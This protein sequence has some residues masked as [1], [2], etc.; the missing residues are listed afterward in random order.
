MDQFIQILT[1]PDNIP[2]VGMI[3][4]LIW[5]MY[6]AQ[7]QTSENDQFLDAGNFDAMVEHMKE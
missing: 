6:V 2:I 4:I 7:K 1:A 3:F 5:V